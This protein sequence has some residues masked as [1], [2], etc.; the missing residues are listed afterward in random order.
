VYWLKI[1]TKDENYIAGNKA[2][3]LALSILSIKNTTNA[4]IR[5]ATDTTI[6]LF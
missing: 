3:M 5:E 1:P 4:M 2:Y 6:T